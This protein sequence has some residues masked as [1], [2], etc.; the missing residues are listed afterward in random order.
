MDLG[1][2]SELFIG[3]LGPGESSEHF[4]EQGKRLY[5]EI[6]TPIERLSERPRTRIED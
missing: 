4:V 2:D 3:I 6:A 5:A 1:D